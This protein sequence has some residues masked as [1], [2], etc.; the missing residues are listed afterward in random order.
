LKDSFV[1]DSRT[2]MIA[3]I[4]PGMASCEHTLNTLRYGYRVKE[5]RHDDAADVPYE[6]PHGTGSSLKGPAS[7]VDISS[8]LAAQ[9]ARQASSSRAAAA[10]LQRPQTGGGPPSDEEDDDR[11]GSSS[12]APATRPPLASVGAGRRNSFGAFGDDSSAAAAAAASA[13]AAPPRTKRNSVGGAS[14]SSA[15]AAV[16]KAV[17]SAATSAG[18]AARQSLGGVG[19]SSASGAAVR[20]PPLISGRTGGGSASLGGAAGAVPPPSAHPYLA[21]ASS[22]GA[23]PAPSS[24]A[25]AHG[26]GT[27]HQQLSAAS[28]DERTS[29]MPTGIP[30]HARAQSA[31]GSAPR[32]GVNSRARAFIAA[33]A[34]SSGPAA[35]SSS[36]V[37]DAAAGAASDGMAGSTFFEAAIA[38]PDDDV[39]RHRGAGLFAQHAALLQRGVP[40][41]GSALLASAPMSVQAPPPP[42]PSSEGAAAAPSVA[43]VQLGLVR[44]GA[45]ARGPEAVASTAAG[46]RVPTPAATST[47]APHSGGGGGGSSATVDS[48]MD[49]GLRAQQQQ[50]LQSPL[51]GATVAGELHYHRYT[52]G[53]DDSDE[54]NT[55]DGE[56]EGA[57]LGVDDE[58][59]DD[60]DPE[61]D[62]TPLRGINEGSGSRSVSDDDDV[63]SA[64]RLSRRRPNDD[65][66]PVPPPPPTQG[67]LGHTSVDQFEL[68]DQLR[69]RVQQQTVKT[70]ASARGSSLILATGPSAPPA[71]APGGAQ[72]A[73]DPAMRRAR[74][75]QERMRSVSQALSGVPLI[76][77]ERRLVQQHRELMMEMSA[78]LR[79]EWRMVEGSLGADSPPGGSTQPGRSLTRGDM[80]QASNRVVGRGGLLWL[81]VHVCHSRPITVVDPPPP[82]CAHVPLFGMR[83]MPPHCKMS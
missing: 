83:S 15:A 32:P 41:G 23:I 61:Y 10:P 45:G 56:E 50:Q 2:V 76:A 72:A 78:L 9:L 80:A 8:F 55:A 36:S 62:D 16:R 58:G 52:G 30:R 70:P 20:A 71:G 14:G 34:V 54:G 64:L 69:A 59:A 53:E 51:V 74:D 46:D 73:E 17:A 81:S 6:P 49:K 60:V 1:G 29:Q 57:P 35:P 38:S 42:L 18:A 22:G 82:P 4:S 68:G 37:S 26:S 11:A 33:N 28:G 31:G 21:R 67:S 3:T 43:H 12:A 19:G 75:A 44:G 24:D 27:S 40:G 7:D 79:D 48:F 5:I 63:T 25:Q 66:S 77:D 47:E 65:D 39:R 13:A